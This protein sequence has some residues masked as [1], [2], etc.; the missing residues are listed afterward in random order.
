[1]AYEKITN[2]ATDTYPFASTGIRS[3]RFVA[4]STAGLTYPN[5]STIGG[6]IIG[7]LISSGT[8]GST[9]C[10][11][12]VGTVQVNDVARVEAE[13]STALVVGALVSASSVGRVQTSTN[14]GDHIVGQLVDGSTGGVNRVVSVQLGH[15]GTA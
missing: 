10:S 9:D 13:S 14:T 15:Q 3:K 8:T 7:V 4:L 2:A 6:R 11:R 12:K 1:M 5:A